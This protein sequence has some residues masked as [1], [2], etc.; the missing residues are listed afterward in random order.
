MC[1]ICLVDFLDS[2]KVVSWCKETLSTTSSH[3]FNKRNNN[4]KTETDIYSCVRHPFKMDKWKGKL[5]LVTGS[6]AGIGA[7]ITKALAN[8][9]MIVI[10]L[11]RR[12]DA[13]EVRNLAN[14]NHQI[15]IRDEWIYL[16]LYFIGFGQSNWIE[17]KWQ[18]HC[19]KVWCFKWSWSIS[20]ISM[21]QR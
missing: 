11:G 13:I 4:H 7:S 18:N 15:S 6:S 16:F 20:D 2:N 12:V 9:G 17:F 3:I 1:I 5:A 19:Q 21:D 14:P 10:G 8:S